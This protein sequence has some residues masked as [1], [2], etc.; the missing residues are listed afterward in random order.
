MNM[1]LRLLLQFKAWMM[2]I[3]CKIHG[4]IYKVDAV[5]F[6]DTVKAL[7]TPWK[8]NCWLQANVKYVS[9]KIDYWQTAQETFSRR[10]G[11]CDDSARFAQYCL[12]RHGY[13]S[14]FLLMWGE[15][16]GHATALFKDGHGYY[17]LGTYGLVPHNTEDIDMV[18]SFFFGNMTEWV[19]LDEELKPVEK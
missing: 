7:D 15:S 8:I 6:E 16:K 1:L 17:T 3:V 13:Q 10:Q 19:L 12:N 4:L 14:F 2:R 5:G 9:D 18:V 11:D